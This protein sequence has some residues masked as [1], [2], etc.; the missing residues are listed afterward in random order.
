MSNKV[1]DEE[2]K[3]LVQ[4]LKDSFGN[5]NYEFAVNFLLAR[6]ESWGYYKS[7]VNINDLYQELQ[8]YKFKESGR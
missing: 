3:I 4:D 1:T 7:G 2:M 8:Y 5:D 6:L